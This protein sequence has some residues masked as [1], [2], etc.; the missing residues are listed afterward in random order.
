MRKRIPKRHRGITA[1]DLLLVWGVITLIIWGLK[2]I[3]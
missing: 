1:K 2:L 3:V